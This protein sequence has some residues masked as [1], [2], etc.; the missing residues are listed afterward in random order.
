MTTV[1][2]PYR[3]PLN[4]ANRRNPGWWVMA[5]VVATE[6]MLFA[7]LLF[8]YYYLW[9]L[10]APP[11]PPDGPPRLTLA[12]PNTVLLLASSGTMWWAERAIRRGAVSRL[13]LGLLA[14]FALGAVFLA[15]QGVEYSRETFTP[16]SHAYGSLFFTIT[17]LH[18]AHVLV[19]LL[20]NAFVQ[21]RAWLGH[22]SAERHLAVS[23]AA[24]YWHFVDAVW[25]AV[26]ASLYLAPR[27][28]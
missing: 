21:A 13:R 18:G 11:W 14:T 9:S 25:L 4:P 2:E 15:L 20:M 10:A 5:L 27:L 6:A 26:F 7:Y 1:A 3:L 8:G 12:A 17:G 22:F 19:G 23:N 24:M 28:A 16:R